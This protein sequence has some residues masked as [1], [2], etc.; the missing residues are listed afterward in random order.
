M[1]RFAA[2][3]QSEGVALGTITDQLNTSTQAAYNAVTTAG[4]FTLTAAQFVN[5]IYQT[6]GQTAA[7]TVNTPT[8]AA[9]VAALPNCQVGSKFEFT[10]INLNTTSGAVTVTG[11]TGVTVT[12]ANGTTVPVT[13]TQIFRGVVTNA[14]AGSE[15]V[16]LYGLLYGGA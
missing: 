11:G 13:K 2:N 6:S 9:I 4:P 14:T 10:L 7:V 16:T 8:A 1:A 12:L 3:A 5:A 15:A